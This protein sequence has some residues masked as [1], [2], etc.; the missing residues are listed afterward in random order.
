MIE[1]DIMKNSRGQTLVE[2]II[3]LPVLLLIIMAIVDLG[4]IFVKKYSM[5]NH[6]D[7]VY[8]LYIDDKN[9]SINDYVKKYGL[10]IN[11]ENEEK[12]LIINL[13]KTININTPILN[14]ILGSEYK[15]EVSR[16][17]HK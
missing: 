10:N 9:D 17:I 12:F 7:D 8:E 4:N 13:S 11:Y 16:A 15:I 14:N 6:I 2:F 1:C 3:V 5:E